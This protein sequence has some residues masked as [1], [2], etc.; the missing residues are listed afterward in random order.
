[1]HRQRFVEV[2]KNTKACTS[3]QQKTRKRQLVEMRGSRLTLH[4]N[5]SRILKSF[6]TTQVLMNL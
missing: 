2:Q 1:M 4:D 3:S 6:A 5:L